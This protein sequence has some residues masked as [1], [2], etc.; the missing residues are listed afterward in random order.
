MTTSDLASQA[1]GGTAFIANAASGIASTNMESWVPVIIQSGAIGLLAF[2]LWHVF[3]K[4]IPKL[5]DAQNEALKNF[6]E[7]SH[8]IRKEFKETLKETVAQLK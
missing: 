8:E 4:I 6:R 5:I 3:T 1:V 7:E 2:V